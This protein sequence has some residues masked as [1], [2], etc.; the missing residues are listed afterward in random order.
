MDPDAGIRKVSPS[1]RVNLAGWLFVVFVV[2]LVEVG[3][4]LFGLDDVVPAPSATVRALATELRSG[5]L[6]GEI[7]TTLT[8]Y[9]E[10][11]ALAILGGVALGIAVGS[12][13]TFRDASAVLIEFLRPIPPITFIPLAILF[14]GL[15][16][17]MR[18]F[19]IAYAALW[20]ILINTLYGVRASDRILHDVAR[21]SR[22][23]G[24]RRLVRVTLPSALPS[25]A[26]GVRVSA[27]IALL[28]G[29]TAEFVTGPDGIGAYMQKQQA[30]YRLPQMYAA[31][32]LTA[33]LGYSINVL[34][35]S[36]ER[37]VVFWSAEERLARR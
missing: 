9:T 14:F 3:V 13:R 33:L 6:S 7:G 24:V 21:V 30:A 4:W 11:L 35:R 22:V 28:V 8:S 16:I 1:A 29:V 17:P 27:S 15:G 23:T 34:L 26:T 25:I 12:S 10:G 36:A 18:R 37:R 2:A 32:L 5:T 19:V 31:I 20:P